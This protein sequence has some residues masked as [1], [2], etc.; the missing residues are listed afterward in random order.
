MNKNF[1]DNIELQRD[2]NL[3]DSGND[4]GIIIKDQQLIDEY[5][6]SEYNAHDITPQ[7]K[8]LGLE[9]KQNYL[10]NDEESVNRDKFYRESLTNFRETTKKESKEDLEPVYI[11]AMFLIDRKS[12]SNSAREILNKDQKLNEDNTILNF[13]VISTTY[14]AKIK[15][16]FDFQ[17]MEKAM[18]YFMEK[19]V[20]IV[21]VYDRF[22]LN[23]KYDKEG[24]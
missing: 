2:S 19:F 4:Q 5:S 7:N 23:I 12:G 9:E 15:H 21:M 24:M 14:F 13:N 16:K 3:V 18:P 11:F 17:R 10:D 1:K 6:G 20:N 8:D 22:P